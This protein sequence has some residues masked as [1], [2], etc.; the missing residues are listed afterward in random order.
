MDLRR[1]DRMSV[2][3]LLLF[4]RA[5]VMAFGIANALI[6][7]GWLVTV[8]TARAAE[9]DEP[10]PNVAIAQIVLGIGGSIVAYLL[11]RGG[12]KMFSRVLQQ[13][14]ADV[15]LVAVVRQSL[16]GI[17]NSYVELLDG[18]GMV[19]A[20][21][22]VPNTRDLDEAKRIIAHYV[23]HASIEDETIE[24]QLSRDSTAVADEVARREAQRLRV[25]AASKHAP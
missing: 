24:V 20:Q 18:R 5:L 12:G 13:R 21:V 23:P 16:K 11:T 1:L 9:Y 25:R 7:A 8:L 22:T 3:P 15:S 17:Q 19:L 2:R 14:S 4:V 6:G 10:I